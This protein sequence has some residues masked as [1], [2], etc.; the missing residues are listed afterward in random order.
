MLLWTLH[1][2]CLKI[3]NNSGSNSKKK[4]RKVW[5][6]KSECIYM[7]VLGLHLLKKD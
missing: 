7:I 2:C 3:N 1:D 5:R 6:L 4:P